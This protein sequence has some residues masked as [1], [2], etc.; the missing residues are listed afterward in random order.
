MYK[1]YFIEYIKQMPHKK[2]GHL[3][4]MADGE[5]LPRHKC[6]RR[7]RDDFAALCLQNLLIVE[8]NRQPRLPSVQ[9][10]AIYNKNKMVINDHLIFMA[11]G[12]GFEPPDELPRQRFSRPSHSTALPTIRNCNGLYY[13]LFFRQRKCKMCNFDFL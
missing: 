2:S 10:D 1:K 11:D 9:P 13:I 5:K 12:E 7:I 3:I 6:L 4:F 8:P